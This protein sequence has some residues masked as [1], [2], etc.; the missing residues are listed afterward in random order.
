MRLFGKSGLQ[1]AVC[2]NKNTL[3]SITSSAWN[4]GLYIACSPLF[5]LIAGAGALSSWNVT[6]S[7]AQDLSD[8]WIAGI[9]SSNPQ[10][11]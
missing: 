11:P 4:L 5:D 10:V 7:T 8:D 9:S 1:I 2:P 3:Y 6:R